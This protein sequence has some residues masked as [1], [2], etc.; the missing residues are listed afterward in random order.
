[1][2]IDTKQTGAKPELSIAR[3]YASNHTALMGRLPAGDREPIPASN[4]YIEYI[5]LSAGG[6]S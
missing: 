3:R 6:T 1:M 2:L 5:G 4:Q